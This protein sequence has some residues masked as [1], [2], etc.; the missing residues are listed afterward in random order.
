MP[1]WE[2]PVFG[3]RQSGTTL[4]KNVPM[5]E[6]MMECWPPV[7]GAVRPSRPQED[8]QKTDLFVEKA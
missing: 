7:D 4:W 3:P 2:P 8:F 1:D 5:P 6:S